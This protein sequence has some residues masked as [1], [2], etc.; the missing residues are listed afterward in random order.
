[1]EVSIPLVF[2]QKIVPAHETPAMLFLPWFPGLSRCRV[3]IAVFGAK[4]LIYL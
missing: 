3:I 1:M 4:T 2:R